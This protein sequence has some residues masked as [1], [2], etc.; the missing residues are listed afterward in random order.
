MELVDRL[1]QVIANIGT[2][3]AVRFAQRATHAKAYLSLIKRG[4]CF[5][6]Y[7][8][9]EG[10]AFA[11]S[12][13]IGYVGNSF[14]KHAAN[15]ARDGRQTNAALNA[16]LSEA[17]VSDATLEGEYRRFC[18]RIG[19]APSRTGTFG[20]SRKYWVTP[21]IRDR[22][23]L[24]AENL[25]IETPGLTQTEKEQII[26][27]RVGQG[28]FRDALVAQWK[29]R[30][31]VTGCAI[32]PVLRASHI[33]PWR[34]STNEERLDRFNGLLLAANIDALFDRGIISFSDGGEI[35]CGP[36]ISAEALASLG[37]DPTRKVKL[38]ARH[39]PFLAHHRDKIFAS[40]T[41]GATVDANRRK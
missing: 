24:I 20:I 3:E 33:K 17:L 34:Q 36:E 7:P 31:C 26:K 5:L 8:T 38:G 19:I 30:C 23:D 32:G 13:F 39:A 15:D 12:R 25:V 10:I 9:S 35:L 37:C 2:L 40:R 41:Q 29:G 16:I 28:A 22:L 18:A 1:D 21:D 27:A 4:T 6:P 14:A 11:P